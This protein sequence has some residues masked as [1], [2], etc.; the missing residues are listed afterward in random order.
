VIT[1]RDA[2]EED[3]ADMVGIL[4]PIV[5]ARAYTALDTQFTVEQQREFIRTFPARGIRKAL[6]SSS[7]RRRV[8]GT[9]R[10]TAGE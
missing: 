8:I 3:A 4:N 2:R 10:Y 7:P 1:I 9:A 6:R 5:V